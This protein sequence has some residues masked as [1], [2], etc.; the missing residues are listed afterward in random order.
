[1]CCVNYLSPFG[2]ILRE[3]LKHVIFRA[4][5]KQSGHV[6]FIDILECCKLYTDLAFQIFLSFKINKGFLK[7][8][9]QQVRERIFHESVAVSVCGWYHSRGV[10]SIS[11][12]RQ[13]DT[14][15]PQQSALSTPHLA[16]IVSAC[17]KKTTWIFLTWVKAVFAGLQILS[18][19]GHWVAAT[20]GLGW[21]PSLR[22]L[23]WCLRG[24]NLILFRL[25]F[26]EDGDL[27]Y[28]KLADLTSDNQM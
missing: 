14:S 19:A 25:T 2:H 24:C 7:K 12:S 18:Q 6:E 3:T 26:G 9:D 1:M 5:S 23:A 28:I 11:H 22:L 8:R 15:L 10:E 27:A 16:A 21:C 17:A 20:W 13:W 4:L